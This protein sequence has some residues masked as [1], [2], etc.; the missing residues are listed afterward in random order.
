MGEGEEEDMEGLDLRHDVE[1]HEL[2]VA[3]QAME[4]LTG[5]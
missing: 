4:D 2:I 1:Y 5:M 3:G